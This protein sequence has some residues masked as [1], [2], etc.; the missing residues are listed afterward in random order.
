[1]YLSLDI[2]A[3]TTD[4]TKAAIALACGHGAD[5]AGPRGNGQALAGRYVL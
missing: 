2:P 5:P 4:A 1:M 3:A